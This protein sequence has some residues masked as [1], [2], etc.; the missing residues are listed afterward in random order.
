MAG[1]IYLVRHAQ[2][3]PSSRIPEREWPLSGHGHR[4]AA[5]LVPLLDTLGID[6]ILS[7]PYRRCL[8]TI[9]P[10]ARSA[11]LE[12][13]IREPL[14][15]RI[16]AP[17]VRTDFRELWE[18]SWTD[19]TF[20]LPGCESSLDAQSRFVEAIRSIA[21]V[22]TGTVAVCA[23]GNVIGLLLDHLR[24]DLGRTPA[25]RLRNPDVVRLDATGGQLVWDEAYALPGLRAIATDAAET[26]IDW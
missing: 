17:S 22:E 24:P 6:R 13:A 5:G 20:A 11:R 4:Q 21:A 12:L 2:S 15:E 9:G 19:R 18:R 14:H 1:R 10:F 16:L 3:F 26:P 8:D 7:S 23:H 25:D